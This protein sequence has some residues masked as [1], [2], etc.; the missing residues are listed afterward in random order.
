MYQN[1]QNSAS[2][3]PPLKSLSMVPGCNFWAISVFCQQQFVFLIAAITQFTWWHP[4][5]SAAITWGVR[6][7]GLSK[8]FGQSLLWA[9]R[10]PPD[11]VIAKPT[12]LFVLRPARPFKEALMPPL[13]S[14]WPLSS[15]SSSVNFSILSRLLLQD[16]Q[17]CQIIQ[18]EIFWFWL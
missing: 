16:Q 9:S 15:A 13:L 11:Q 4:S 5:A 12:L 2:I 1:Q 7:G 14:L 18:I 8:N 3:R 6:W 17:T 10:L